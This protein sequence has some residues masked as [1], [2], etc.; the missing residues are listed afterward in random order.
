MNGDTNPGEVMSDQKK[1]FLVKAVSY[2]Q[3]SAEDKD[4]N[5]FVPM[6]DLVNMRRLDVN[7]QVKSALAAMG[8]LALCVRVEKIELATMPDGS[9]S[10]LWYDIPAGVILTDQEQEAVMMAFEHTVQYGGQ[11]TVEH[12]KDHGGEHFHIVPV[13]G[14]HQHPSFQAPKVNIDETIAEF[15]QAMEDALG[16]SVGEGGDPPPGGMGI[17]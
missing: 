17:W 12:C 6:K 4:L 3:A 7:S 11:V 5:G 15:T 14:R 8:E 9:L 13:T 2:I 10:M 16:P 1:M